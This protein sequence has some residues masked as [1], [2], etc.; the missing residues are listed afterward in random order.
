MMNKELFVERLRLIQNFESERETLGVL[1]DKITD[2]HSV[3]NIGDY[4][5]IE[6]IDMIAESMKLK[7]RE[8]INWWLYVDVEKVIFVDEI[9]V[10]IDTP[11]KLYDYI[12][13]YK[14]E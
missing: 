6:M 2:G 13:K 1:I 9:E 4:L 11:E 5:V 12:V 8:L 10:D 14:N 7:D 3:V